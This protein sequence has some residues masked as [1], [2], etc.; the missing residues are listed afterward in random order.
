MEKEE[1]ESIINKTESKPQSLVKNG[2]Y[3][4][5]YQILKIIVPLITAPYISRVLGVSGVGIYSYTNS[6][7]AYFILVAGLGTA[8]YGVREIARARLD[9]KAYSKSFFEIE[10]ITVFTSFFCIITWLILSFFYTQYNPL[11]YIWTLEIVAVIFDI[12]WLYAG[13]EK[14][15][16]T[17]IINS[18]FKLLGVLFI[19]LFVK[20]QNDLSKYILINTSVVL[21]GNISMWIFLPQVISVT[22]IQFSNLKYHLKET[23]VFFI[24]TIASTMYT[25]L[26][27][28][29]IGLICKNDDLNGYY[30]QGT[31]IVNMSKAVCAYGIIGVIAPRMS[32]L[33]KIDDKEGIKRIANNTLNLLLFFAIAITFGVIAIADVLVPCFFGEGYSEVVLVLKLMMPLCLITTISSCLS[34]LYYTPIGKRKHVAIFVII[35]A[36][37]N[38]C[39]NLLLIPF[40]NIYGAIIGS[41]IAETVVLILYYK[42]SNSFYTLADFF[43]AFWKKIIAALGMFVTIYFLKKINY[44]FFEKEIINLI[45]E[46]IILIVSGAF[47]YSVICLILKDQFMINV[48]KKI[49][50]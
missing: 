6:L 17:V 15:K 3:F 48:F 23:I 40:Y 50:K 38:V 36:L 24:P 37:I 47:V 25:V 39:C 20:H 1:N 43:K 41:L 16:Y 35:A 45:I 14:F 2:F 30:E 28:T 44:T 10:L 46:N 21:C 18:I 19:F 49:I 11:L 9:R 13:I 29:L 4:T 32:F 27:K 8:Q 26:D 5:F 22:K 42:Y 34:N 31:K 12:S 33:F 7:V